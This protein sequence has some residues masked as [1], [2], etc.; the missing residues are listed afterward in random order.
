[1]RVLKPIP[2]LVALLAVF[3]L[4]AGVASADVTTDQSASILVFPK[5]IA[6][7]TRDTLIQISNT[8][9]G[10]VFAHCYY[11]NASLEDPTLPEGPDNGRRWQETDFIMRLTRQQPTIW[12][13]STGRAVNLG[14]SSTC[15]T[16]AGVSEQDCPGIDPGLV[17]TVY[18]PGAPFEGELKCIQIM[19]DG[20]PV[21]GNALKGEATIEGASNLIST[22]NAIGIVGINGDVD[23]N[24]QLELDNNEY[25]ACPRRLILPH[26]GQGIASSDPGLDALGVTPPHRVDTELTIVPCSEAFEA[27]EPTSLTVNID[28]VDEL[29]LTQ[30]VDGVDV[31]CWFN[32]SLNTLRDPTGVLIEPSFSASRSTVL[33]TILRSSGGSGSGILAVAENFR[34]NNSTQARTGSDAVNLLVEGLRADADTISLSAGGVCSPGSPIEGELCLADSD[35]GDGFECL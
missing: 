13:V 29:E 12:R 21:A 34:V 19:G 16:V 23:G 1:M 27:Q 4:S 20:N 25:N 8:S 7:G 26:L 5:V 6:D 35:C 31:E 9:N 32:R 30:S 28:V 17:P 10:V 33:K 3:T 14:T 22:Y 24:L 2:W 18:A 15:T 11:V